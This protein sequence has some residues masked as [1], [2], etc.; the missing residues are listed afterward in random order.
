[1]KRQSPRSRKTANEDLTAC[2]TGGEPPQTPDAWN[3]RVGEKEEKKEE[4]QRR[5]PHY[6]RVGPSYAGPCYA[7][8]VPY[9]HFVNP[10][11]T[12]LYQLT[13]VYSYW[14]CEKTDQDAVFDVFFR[15]APFKGS[16]VVFCGLDD[17][18][19]FVNDFGFGESTVRWLKEEY[20]TWDNGFWDYLGKLDCSKLQIDAVTEGTVVFPREPMLRIS[21]PLGL[22]QLL[23]TTIL[24]SVNYA[25]LVATN[26]ARHRLI[27]GP[28][29]VLLEFGL[30]RAQGADGGM[31]ASKYT[32]V[33]GYNGSSNVLAKR[34]YDVPCK[35]TH[36][37]SYVGSFA[38]WSDFP[39]KRKMLKGNPKN[40]DAPEK[41]DFRDRVEH[42]RKELDTKGT[43]H[44]GELVAF[45]SYAL[46]FADGFLALIDTYDTIKS[47]MVNFAIVSMALMEAGYK[48]VGIRIDSGDLGQQAY[49]IR[50]YFT[51]LAKKYKK[52]AFNGFGI[53]ASNDIDEE[54]L[55][56]L[57][58]TPVTGY[59]VGTNLV[60]CK[61]NP[62]LGG[63][64]K[65][66]E[67]NG[68][69]RIKL[70]ADQ[71]KTTIPAKKQC[72]RVFD[73][74]GVMKCDV[75]THA[76]EKNGPEPGTE[77]KAKKWMSGDFSVQ[78]GSV[79]RLLETVWAD[80]KVVVKLPTIHELRKRVQENIFKIPAVMTR[81]ERPEAYPVVLHKNLHSE[82]MEMIDVA[83]GKGA[84][85]PNDLVPNAEQQY[86][87]PE[88]V[89]I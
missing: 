32:Y 51:T 1:M 63:V 39:M 80:G 9:N 3:D 50:E 88:Q 19:R 22:V 82:T 60:T 12:D 30:R 23:E 49:D 41:I 13:M 4:V 81:R 28:K 8:F 75:L 73:K 77:F 21:G 70:S 2:L 16:F 78:V 54:A 67:L 59:G 57:C 47:G 17:V 76:E 61:G 64:Y 66:V 68:K 85:V 79:K 56:K 69:P 89:Q 24:N 6:E 74:D 26:A 7:S 86:L 5:Q 44:T 11:L 72:Y 15:K 53:V 36:A 38:D 33:G 35:G 71:F 83:H 58:K 62:A 31:T 46:D 37:H 52:E 40:K 34:V 42:W 84:L 45:T 43:T 18:L 25:S 48:P 87:E 20:P 27:V 14:N 65:L 29:P 10:L 55:E